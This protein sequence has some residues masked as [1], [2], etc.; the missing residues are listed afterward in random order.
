MNVLKSLFTNSPQGIEEECAEFVID[1]TQTP[2]ILSN[3][4]TTGRQYTL[5]IWIRADANGSLYTG[6]TTVAVTTQWQKHSITFTAATKNVILSFRTVGTYYIYH[7]QLEAG[8]QSTDW[9]L[10]PEDIDKTIEDAQTETNKA[11]DS[12]NGRIT[13][14][15]SVIQQLSNCISMLITDAN[16]ESLMTQTENGWTFSMKET[17]EAV[18]A[19]SS[20][21]ESLQQETGNTKATVDALNQAV[22]DHGTTLEY[23][24]ITTYEDEPCIE[25]G[26]SDSDFKLR[27]TNTRIMFM[28]GSNIPTYIN[29]NGLVTQNIEIRGELIQ[30]GYVQLNTP[31][32]GWGLLWKGVSS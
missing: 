1:N 28:N 21:M 4:A 24:N 29:T 27:I 15:E 26:E 19:L 14:A 10:A 11:I 18:S 25:L 23:V 8:S 3:I 17:N 12:A 13:S 30:G 7:A 20:L 2:F 9:T 22:K 32:G 16:G 5:T 6:N 31:D